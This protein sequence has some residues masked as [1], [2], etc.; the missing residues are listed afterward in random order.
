MRTGKSLNW[1][2]P[3]GWMV[4]NMDLTDALE[5]NTKRNKIQANEVHFQGSAV[6][7]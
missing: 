4:K 7:I 1:M 6:N 3:N 5:E 2:M